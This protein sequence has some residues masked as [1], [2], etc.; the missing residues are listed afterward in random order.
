M[1]WR[2]VARRCGASKSYVAEVAAESGLTR[3]RSLVAALPA[4][5]DVSL[6]V[7]FD[8]LPDHPASKL[9]EDDD[10]WHAFSEAF[11]S[12]ILDMIPA[13]MDEAEE[14]STNTDEAEAF[15]KEKISAQAHSVAHATTHQEDLKNRI[16]NQ[17]MSDTTDDD[18]V[19]YIIGE[20]VDERLDSL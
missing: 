6:P 2:A 13:Y 12:E 5:D 1:L 15:I 4:S 9:V 14:S 10:A 18:R 16:V 11:R 7:T 3:S 8:D 17:L 19:E 20:I